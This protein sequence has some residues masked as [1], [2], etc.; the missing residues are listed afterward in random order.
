MQHLISLPSENEWFEFKE[1]KKDYTFDKIGQYF[2]ALSNEAN[3]KAQSK[4]WLVFGVVDKTREIIGTHYR[5]N[6]AQL[7]Q[8]KLEIASRTNGLTFNEI[9]ELAVAGE[10]VIMFEIPAAL[11]GIP[12]SWN[13]HFFG[14]DGESLGP[15]KLNEIDLIRG[16]ARNHDWSAEICSEATINDLDKHPIEKARDEYKKK[17]SRSSK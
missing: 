12:T 2:S 9:H 6:R 4:G 10:R 16:E 1:A 8:L 14:R 5:E 15:L 13:G 11:K 3:L 17:A 7:D